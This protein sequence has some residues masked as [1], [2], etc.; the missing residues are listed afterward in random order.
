MVAPLKVGIAGLGTVGAEVVRLIEQQGA[1]LAAR[2]GRGVRVVA[3]T[4]RSKA[5]KRGLDLRGIGWV[6]SPQALAEDS[7]V[8]CFVELMGGADDPAFSAIETALKAGKSVVTANKALIAKHGLRLA[9]AAEQNGGA[10]NFE[11]AV[12]AAIPVIKT[13]REGLCGT[14]V[15]RVYGILNGTCNYIL[16]RMEQEGLSFEEC[17][18]DAQRL[19]YAEANPAFDVDGHDTAQKLAILASLAFGTKVAQTAV[20]VEGISSITPEDL[21]AAE[22]LGY[23]VKLLGVAVR[24]AKGIEQRVHPTMVPKSSSIAQVMGVTNAVTIDGEGIPPITLVGPGAGGAAT[25]SAVVADIAD[26][27][28]GIRATPFGRPVDSLRATTKAPM[29]RHEG[30][31]YIRLLARDHAG[32]AATIARRL[33][34]QKISLESIVQRHRNGSDVNG[35]T[36]KASP[37]PVILITYA[38]SEDAVHRALKAVQ[39]DRVIS[40]RPQVI[41]IEKN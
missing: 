24:T 17:L 29:E 39:R 25:A 13:L 32:T 23:R 37:V 14:S 9:K 21:R 26:V 40:G 10:L 31:Y 7:N 33:A 27:A 41:R 30:G 12:G 16:T 22:E 38:T 18:K 8:D 5:K 34:E 4:A 3:V 2:S 35:S 28:R 11:A 36:K 19:G 1:T 6:E 15:N 20:Y